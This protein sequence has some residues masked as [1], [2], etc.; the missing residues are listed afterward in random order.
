MQRTYLNGSDGHLYDY[1]VG[2][3]VYEFLPSMN[4]LNAITKAMKVNLLQ[5]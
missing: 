2:A 3:E 4:S 1:L 5:S